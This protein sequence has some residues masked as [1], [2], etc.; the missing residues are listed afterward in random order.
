MNTESVFFLRD[1][2]K[3]SV[4]LDV[5]HVVRHGSSGR[6]TANPVEGRNFSEH[7]ANDPDKVTVEAT[8]ADE[9]LGVAREDGRA[10]RMYLALERVKKAGSPVELVTDL[11]RYEVVILDVSTVED[12]DHEDSLDVVIVCQ[13]VELVSLYTVELVDEYGNPAP[14][15][16]GIRDPGKG[17]KKTPKVSTPEDEDRGSLLYQLYYGD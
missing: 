14:A 8:L 6:A 15:A 1:N 4:V 7:F 2:E 12:G 17:G 10:R 5:V 13:E 16:S 11:K 9:P 3:T